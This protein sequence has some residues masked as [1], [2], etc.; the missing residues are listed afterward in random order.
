MSDAPLL[1]VRNLVKTFRPRRRLLGSGSTGGVQAVADVSFDIH[2][3]EAFSLVGESGC[4]KSTTARCVTRIV[5]PTSGSIV[6]D[7]TELA[8]LDQTD[9]QPLRRRFQMVFQDPQASLNPRQ[10]VREII[11]EPL[12]VHGEQRRTVD[13]RV[14]ELAALVHLRRDDLDRF[15]HQFSGGQRQRVGIARALALQPDLLVLDEPVSALD[16]S[17]QAQIVR[18]LDELRDRT[19]LAYLLIAHDL[20]VVRH[21]SDRVGVMYLGTLVETGP[22]AAVYG[23]PQHPYTQ[24]LI[25]AAPI[26]D[27][28][29]ERARRRIVLQGD[30]PSPLDPPSGCRFRTRCWKATEVCSSV[31]PTL[32]DHGGGHQV[33]CHHP[34]PVDV[35]TRLTTT[36]PERT[37]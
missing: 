31:V 7:G 8:G 25:S 36:R 37:E 27:P 14:D 21:L 4:G 23:A 13:Q 32:T 12:I 18:L 20:A 35:V 19:G 33:A 1:T 10:R 3:G 30:V 34:E 16:V 26:A 5:E 22:R 11:G 9:L 17:I 24:A 28:D 6:F 29:V 2:R 15:P